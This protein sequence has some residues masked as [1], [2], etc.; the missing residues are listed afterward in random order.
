MITVLAWTA[1]VM[2]VVFSVIKK[3]VGLRVSEEEE[4]IGL[5]SKEHGHFHLLMRVSIMDI[6]EGIMTEN[7]NTDLGVQEYDKASEAQKKA[8]VSVAGSVDPHTGM[9][10][11][12]S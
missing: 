9:L 5:D 2:F 1:V 12:L 4:I 3:T 6:T 10:K 11:S 8:S 7:E